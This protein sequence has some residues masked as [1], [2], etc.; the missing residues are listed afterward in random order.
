MSFLPSGYQ[1]LDVVRDRVG[2][3]HLGSALAA[4]NLRAF[5]MNACGEL[6]EMPNEVWRTQH[7]AEM[8]TSGRTIGHF[9]KLTRVRGTGESILVRVGSETRKPTLVPTPTREAPASPKPKR[10]GRPPAEAW[11][12]IAA[13]AAAFIHDNGVPTKQIDLVRHIQASC[14]EALGE[15]MIKRFVSMYYKAITPLV[16]K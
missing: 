3:D 6:H 16:T 13:V 4:G 5:R 11:P 14:G 1:A 10:E 7:A 9:N 2:A 8:M 12:Q 15:T